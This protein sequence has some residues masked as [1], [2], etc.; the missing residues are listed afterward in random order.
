MSVS[1]QNRRRGQSLVA[2]GNQR[3][4]KLKGCS[5]IKCYKITLAITYLVVV[6]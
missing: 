4:K 6:N 1:W 3:L 5:K 2:M